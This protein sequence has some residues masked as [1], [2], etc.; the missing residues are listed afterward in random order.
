MISTTNSST[1]SK[2]HVPERATALA[3]RLA[4]AEN[5]LRALTSGQVDAIIDPDGKA[6]LLRP[7]QESL[8]RDEQR[9]RAIL[10]YSP[11]AVTVVDRGG[12]I[13]SQNRASKRVIGQEPGE[14]VG[15]RIFEFVK[16]EDLPLL[17][18]AYFNVIEGFDECGTV[19]FRFRDAHGLDRLVEA[20]IAR[21]GGI[22]PASV[23]M[24]IRLATNFLATAPLRTGANILNV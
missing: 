23:V 14:M 3:L 20:T 6:Y 5:A 22:S 12:V 21:L 15:R 19:R 8:I 10:D 24:S 2:E 17:Y 11:D 7:A 9:L 13:L 18:I 4:H 1:P 16:D